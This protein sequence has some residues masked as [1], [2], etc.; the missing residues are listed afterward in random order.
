MPSRALPPCLTPS[1]CR[2]PGAAVGQG[3]IYRI[4]GIAP[5]VCT[6]YGRHCWGRALAECFQSGQ[7]LNAAIVQAG[8]ALAW[9]PSTGAVLGPRYD[10]QQKAAAAERAGM[11]RGTFVEPWV[12]RAQ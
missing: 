7:S 1:P 12:W 3:Q 4:F 10:D 2:R 9:Y 5:I 11:W 8:W 6:V